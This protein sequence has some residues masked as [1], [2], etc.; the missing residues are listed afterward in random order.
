MN[1]QV[2]L[3]GALRR[4]RPAGALAQADR[5]RLEIARAL[6]SQP[7][8]LLLDEP[9]VGMDETETQALIADIVRLRDVH[10]DLSVI[11]IE[12][13]M[14]VVDAF[15]DHVMCIDYGGRIAEGDFASVRANPRVQEAY[16]GKAAAHA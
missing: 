15:P 9:S 10:P 5:R 7:K 14:Q 11:L 8:L 2:K 3:Y 12:H 4:Y 6:A 16:L 1:V 13:D